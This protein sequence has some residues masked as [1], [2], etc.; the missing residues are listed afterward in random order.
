[1]LISVENDALR[2]PDKVIPPNNTRAVPPSMEI[3]G[4]RVEGNEEMPA[5]MRTMMAASVI[6]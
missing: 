5:T 4:W 3:A 1:M 6:I 2:A